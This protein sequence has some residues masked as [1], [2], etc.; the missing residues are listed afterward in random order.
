MADT[1]LPS[2]ATEEPR[3]RSRKCRLSFSGV[4]SPGSS[5]GSVGCTERWHTLLGCGVWLSLDDVIGSSGQLI[6]PT[7]ATLGEVKISPGEDPDLAMNRKLCPGH[8]FDPRQDF[9]G[10]W[11]GS[12]WVLS[13]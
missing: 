6:P 8:N 7:P 1:R 12:R 11:L 3:R 5:V 4:G 13:R 2:I 9:R 10:A